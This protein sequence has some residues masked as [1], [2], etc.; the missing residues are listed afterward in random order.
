MT[1]IKLKKKECHTHW[2]IFTAGTE[3]PVVPWMSYRCQI[4]VLGFWRARASFV[5]C[6]DERD[7][8]YGTKSGSGMA[9][10]LSIYHPF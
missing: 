4:S 9:K 1:K 5:S 6:L 2:S 3:K 7:L 10:Y 8:I